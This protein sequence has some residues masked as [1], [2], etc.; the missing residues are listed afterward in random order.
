[1]LRKIQ[2]NRLEDLTAKKKTKKQY[3]RSRRDREGTGQTRDLADVFPE[4]SV[5]FLRQRPGPRIMVGENA[6]RLETAANFHPGVHSPGTS[7]LPLA[8]NDV[9]AQSRVVIEW[10]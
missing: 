9:R 5:A 3:E 2:H 10:V 4:R 6:R 1:M 8:T 7:S